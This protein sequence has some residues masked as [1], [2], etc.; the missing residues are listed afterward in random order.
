MNKLK[1][2]MGQCNK[3]AFIFNA[4]LSKNMNTLCVLFKVFLRQQL[5]SYINYYG[6]IFP[7]LVAIYMATNLSNSHCK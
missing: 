4:I 5:H 7:G 3:D 6:N 1:I 2:L